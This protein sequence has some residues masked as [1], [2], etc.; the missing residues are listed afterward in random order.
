[1]LVRWSWFENQLSRS[2]RDS[3]MVVEFEAKER[4]EVNAVHGKYMVFASHI[5]PERRAYSRSLDSGLVRHGHRGL[6]D[7][8]PRLLDPVK[9]AYGRGQPKKF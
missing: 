4:H 7:K 9:P 2:A 1:M 8:R 3:G 5:S 6:E